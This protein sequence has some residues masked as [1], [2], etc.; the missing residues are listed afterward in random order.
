MKKV[1][2]MHE[3]GD[4]N[5][6]V[7]LVNATNE[8]R[9][10]KYVEFSPIKIVVKALI[11]GDISKISKC[12]S[13]SI[14]LL[15]CFFFPSILRECHVVLGMA[16]LDMKIFFMARVLSSSNVTYHTSWLYWDGS[17]YPKKNIIL[18]RF[19]ENKWRAFFK[20]TVVNF[21]VV[22]ERVADQLC[23]YFDIDKK[24]IFVVYHAYH[25]DIFIHRS[26][27]IKRPSIVFAGRLVKCKGI[28]VILSL[29]KQ[30]PGINFNIAG[31]GPLQKE[32]LTAQ[33]NYKNIVY[34]GFINDKYKLA[35]LFNSNQVILLP[36]FRSNDWEELFGISLI[37]AMS[38]GCIPITTDHYGPQVILGGSPLADFSFSEETFIENAQSV[39]DNLFGSESLAYH[40]NNAIEVSSKYKI[41]SISKIWCELINNLY[42]NKKL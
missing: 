26:V 34:H 31:C 24:R 3:Y 39:I 42:L 9:E 20:T 8:N 19:I 29:A 37:E 21:A 6:Y 11:K 14:F 17:K 2:V 12:V 35:E 18:G 30:N 4:P 36:S 40:Q 10:I 22:T 5:H 38:C 15:K 41:P 33:E 16:P 23:S 25:D 1:I 28:D 27:D 7:G 13:D 32:V